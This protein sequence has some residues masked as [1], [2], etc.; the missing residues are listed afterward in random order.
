MGEAQ[1]TCDRSD[2]TI[3]H[4]S[5]LPN[6]KL[7]HTLDNLP[8]DSHLLCPIMITIPTTSSTMHRVFSRVI[9]KPC[10]DPRTDNLASNLTIPSPNA[11]SHCL[12]FDPLEPVELH[13]GCIA[14]LRSIQFT[15]KKAIGLPLCATTDPSC[16]LLAS[17]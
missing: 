12:L 8:E 3:S 1:L 10:A 16:S 9:P 11:V 14:L 5:N 17:V 4:I 2:M 13:N 7:A 6:A 15:R